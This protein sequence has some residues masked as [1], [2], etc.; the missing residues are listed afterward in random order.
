MKKIKVE[1]E[2]V[3][4]LNDKPISEKGKYVLYWM[5]QSQRVDYNHALEYAALKAN[6]LE[7]PLLVVFGLMDDYPEAN[8][9]H[10]RFMLEGL[11]DTANLLSKRNINFIL[12]KGT[13]PEI[14]KEFA[15]DAAIVFCDMGYLRH[16]RLWRKQ[17]SETVSCRVVQVESDTVVPV[18]IASTKAEYAAR[19]IRR[20][21]WLHADIFIVPLEE[22][23]LKHSSLNLNFK[24]T[25]SLNSIDA[26]MASLKLDASVGKVD[27]F[28][29]G[30]PTEA[31]K[32]LAHFIAKKLAL[33]V[34]NRN[35]P[36]TDDISHMSMY[37]H[38]GQISPVEILLAIKKHKSGKENADSYIEEL[39]VRRELSINF[40]YYTSDY[41][42]YS[43]LPDW[44]KNTL[45]KHKADERPHRYTLKQ[46]EASKTHDPYWN[47]SMDEMKITGFMHNYMRMYWGKKILEWSDTP[48]KAY[49]N[50]IYLNNKYFLDGRDPASY[51]NIGWIFGLHDRPWGE[52]PI[53][54]TVRT[55][56]AS[57]LERKT[58][59]KAYIEKVNLLKEKVQKKED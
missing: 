57:G 15:D 23:K 56:V 59:P 20:K 2:R 18:E 33:Y 55:M 41:D 6:E 51:A 8:L 45:E 34:E 54:G 43:F 24:N 16:Q 7:L 28:F 49:K 30:G 5:Q 58:N 19:T 22:V 14:A 46:L 44:A 48:E 17:L 35:Q 47:A 10:Y 9:R 37:L 36:Y 1:K 3:K 42:R 21:I 32:R 12:K 38:F 39:L 4:L 40:V 11:R 26:L 29:K 52:R 27:Q 31:K 13:P 25:L 53:Y 50:L